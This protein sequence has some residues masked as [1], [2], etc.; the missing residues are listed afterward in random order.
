M[1]TPTNPTQ[2]TIKLS[3]LKI[4][5]GAVVDI[6]S[7]YLSLKRSRISYD[8]WLLDGERCLKKQQLR[9]LVLLTHLCC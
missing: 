9:F 6:W 2:K 8:I 4:Y 7:I 3:I 5:S 1:F